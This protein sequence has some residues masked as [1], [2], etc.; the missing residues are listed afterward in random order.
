MAVVAR[1]EVH[2]PIL[3]NL[4]DELARTTEESTA[5]AALAPV[6]A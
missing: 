2:S 3:R 4:L 5:V 1:R 6:A